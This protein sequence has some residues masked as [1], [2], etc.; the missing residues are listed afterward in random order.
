M[1]EVAKMAEKIGLMPKDGKNKK[2][3]LPTVIAVVIILILL[4]AGNSLVLFELSYFDKFYPGSAIGNIKLA[5][6]TKDQAF[7]IIDEAAQKIDQQGAQVEYASGSKQEIY[8]LDQTLNP[9]SANDF[10]D[11]DVY[12]TVYDNYDLGHSGNW[13]QRLLTQWLLLNNQIKQTASLKLNEAYLKKIISNQLLSQTSQETDAKPEISCQ[14]N[15]CQVAILPEKTGESFNYDEALSLWKNNLSLLDYQPIRLKRITVEPGIRQ[16][17]VIGMTGKLQ[18]FFSVSTSPE[19]YYQDKKWLI[20]KNNLAK[21][22]D[23]EQGNGNVFIS[24]NKDNFNAW[25]DGNIG[26][27]LDIPAQ[28]A[29]VQVQDGKVIS[30]S[31]HR[32]GQSADKE[33]A[34]LD[35][36]AKIINQDFGSM[37]FELS[38]VSTT[39]EVMTENINNLGIKEIIG[40][41]ESNFAGSPTNR[42]KNIRNGA[43]K[44]QGLLIK[45]GEEFSLIKTLL[46]VDASTGYFPELVIKGNKTTPEFGGGLCQIGTTVFRA[47]LS[48]GLPILERQNHSYSVTYY[49]E[50]GLPGVDATIYDPK[51]DLRFKNDTGNYILIQSHIIGNKLTFEFWGTKDGRTASH[52]KPKTWGVKDPLPAKTLETTDLQP[53]VKKCTESAHKG[54]SAS[55]DYIVNYPDN[56][57]ATTTFTSVYK[58]WQAVC[59]VGVAATSTAGVAQTKP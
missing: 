34:Y 31:S 19:Y 39:P 51:P 6:L 54:I 20:N 23:F 50:N 40:S 18:D 44:L 58:P 32:S 11:Y 15:N 45:P 1:F 2:W 12:K 16:E 53:G 14:N 10:L 38:V 35:L 42:I 30:L 26:K 46:P 4:V 36:K 47:A 27:E 57:T 37:R 3:L 55:F 28:N 22:I 13:P 8:L 9:D 25:F 33:K 48:T 43:A 5:G 52:T 59:L 41:G 29:T 17:D 7:K 49:L 24:V 56:H 21:I